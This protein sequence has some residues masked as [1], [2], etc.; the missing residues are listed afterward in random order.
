MIGR[1]RLPCANSSLVFLNLKIRRALP[2]TRDE[3][4][5]ASPP[6]EMP[7]LQGGLEGITPGG[8]RGFVQN[9]I[10]QSMLDAP[11]LVVLACEP[12][13][14]PFNCSAQ[15]RASATAK[16]ITRPFYLHRLAELQRH[17]M[18]AVADG[19]GADDFAQVRGRLSL[20][21]QPTG[22]PDRQALAKQ[23]R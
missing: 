14:A 20:D 9:Q 13:T 7:E 10:L 15:R 2:G 8:G 5:I 4:S 23:E 16:R 19:A 3:S 1:A 22:L 11:C 12:L 21:G 18:A 17:F 6:T